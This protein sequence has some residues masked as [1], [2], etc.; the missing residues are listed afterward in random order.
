MKNTRLKLQQHRAS[1]VQ[2]LLLMEN[3]KLIYIIVFFILCYRSTI[4]IIENNKQK[5]GI[6]KKISTDRSKDNF[7]EL[8]FQRL[9]S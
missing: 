9:F 1:Y 3:R 2:K 6:E 4:N 5:T 8:S 7:E